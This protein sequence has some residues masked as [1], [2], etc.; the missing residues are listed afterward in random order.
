LKRKTVISRKTKVLFA[1]LSPEVTM[2]ALIMA[3]KSGVKV[4]KHSPF[5][6]S[7]EEVGLYYIVGGYTF[8]VKGDPERIKRRLKEMV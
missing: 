1:K 7:P 2:D 4:I 5:G 8:K 3:K 6:L